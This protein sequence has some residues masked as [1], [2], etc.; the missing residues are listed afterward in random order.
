M[1]EQQTET[2]ETKKE[3]AAVVKHKYSEVTL[4]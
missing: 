2:M 1:S 4:E 3:P